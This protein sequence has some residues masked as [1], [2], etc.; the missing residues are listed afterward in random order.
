VSVRHVFPDWILSHFAQATDCGT[1][2]CGHQTL[3]VF[4]PT[5]RRKRSMVELVFPCLCSCGRRGHFVIGMHILVFGYLLAN[6]VFVKA[7]GRGGTGFLTIHPRP[8]PFVE[9]VL[10]AFDKV[11][12]TYEEDRKLKL[13]DED[14]R[15][16]GLTEEEWKQFQRRMGFSNGDL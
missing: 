16:L 14:R 12:S 10:G 15:S 8:S 3:E 5:V 2:G 11:I 1:A 4:C 13:T 6:V 7:S 9:K